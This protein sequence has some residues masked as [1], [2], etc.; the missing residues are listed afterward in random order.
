MPK[1]ILLSFALLPAL[2]LGGCGSTAKNEQAEA[3]AAIAADA[4]ATMGAA[5]SDV[6][7]AADKAIGGGEPGNAADMMGSASNEI[8]E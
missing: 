4:N 2:A 3:A 8:V 6:D 5:V 1:S 7:A